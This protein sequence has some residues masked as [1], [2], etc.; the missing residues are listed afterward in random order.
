MIL[1]YLQLALWLVAGLVSFYFSLGSA[2]VW[3]SIALGFFLVLIGEIIPSAIPFLPGLDLA[4]VRALGY[5]V[6]TIAI[7]VMTHGF[8]EYYIFSRTLELE[9]RRRWVFLGTLAVLAGS[10]L[11][12]LVNPV[13]TPRTIETIHIIENATWTFLALVNL[14][15]IRK[16]YANV[17]GSPIGNGFLAFLGVFVS[18]FLWKGSQLYIQVYDLAAVAASFPF[19]YQLSVAVANIGNLLSSVAVGAT[20]LYLARRLR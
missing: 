4:E 9:G 3:T 13:P 19:R 6:S 17:K 15:L 7:M 11:F 14:D 1:H 18:I 16:I 12:V 10:V 8:Q 2:R 5:I 20:F